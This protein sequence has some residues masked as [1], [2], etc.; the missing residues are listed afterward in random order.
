[1]VVVPFPR[2]TGAVGVPSTRTGCSPSKSDG[3]STGSPRSS[4]AR[5]SGRRCSSEN[6]TPAS[7]RS[8]WSGTP[9]RLAAAT[10]AAEVAATTVGEIEAFGADVVFVWVLGDASSL[11]ALASS[12]VPDETYRRFGTYP[13]ELGG[14]VSDS[15]AARALVAVESGEEYDARYPGFAE[16]RRRLGSESLVAMPLRTAR[17]EVV[18]AIFAASRRTR[19]VS[20]DRRPL[21]LGVAEQTGV[22]LERARLQAE[23]EAAARA[24]AFLVLLGESLERP[25]TVSG[26]ARRVVEELIDERATFV[27]VHLADEDGV[28]EEVASGGSRPPELDDE[29][30][31]E[32]VHRVASS[33]RR[34]SIDA[35]ASPA[36]DTSRPSLLVLPLRARGHILGALTLRIAAGA[37]W[38]PVMS[39]SVAR[40]I[41]DRAALALDNARL[42]EREREVSH[43]LQLGLLGGTLPAFERVVVAAAYRPGTAALDVGG[44]WYDA[45]LLESGQLSLVVGDVVGHGLEAAVAMGQLRGAVSAL[46]QTA[47]P[48]LLLDRLDAF[49]EAVPSAATATL[50]Y[51]ELDTETG[52]L[53]YACA[54]HPPPLVVSPDGRTRFLWDGRSAPLGSMFGDA[55]SEAAEQLG[56]GETLVLYTDGLVERRTA[57]IDEGL[58]RLVEL[59]RLE[60]LGAPALADSIC[61]RILDGRSQDDDVCVMTIYRTPTVS[62]FSHTLTAAPSELAG[63]RQHLREWL[64]A[65]GVADDVERG[66]VLAASEAAANAVEHAYGCNGVG[67]VTVMARFDEE[68]VALTVRDEGTWRTSRPNTDRG[69]GLAIMQAL[70]DDFSI[71]QENGATVLR[72]SHSAGAPSPA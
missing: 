59:A 57:S 63:L 38:K 37:D 22:A 8:S 41:A 11:E 5:S 36:G 24:D 23:A 50:A 2:A 61:D 69:R 32:W 68:R 47:G 62:M 40:E 28:L 4:R 46:A 27:A 15:M 48:A 44:D 53:R 58:R 43:R 1:M 51:V 54:G 21:L 20:A 64:D 65:N 66:I 31:R 3:C 49:V 14:L 19:W 16:E 67:I 18:G 35:V 17:G 26:R 6:A 7:R 39:P 70:A 25:T 52:N 33:G 60:P 34:A 71:E 10:T 9:P 12:S 13:L 56:E 29:Y 30:W 45:A 42:Y 72:M 55:R